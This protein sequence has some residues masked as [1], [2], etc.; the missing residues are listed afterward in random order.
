MVLSEGDLGFDGEAYREQLV[1][2][3]GPVRRELEEVRGLLAR[4]LRAPKAELSEVF[5][6]LRVTSGRLLRP[7]VLLL[8]GRAAGDLTPGHLAA[9]V[10]VEL[11]H[12]ASLIH[13]DI[14]DGTRLRRGPSACRPAGDPARLCWWGTWSSDGRW[15]RREELRGRLLA[16]GAC[17]RVR[18][19]AEDWLRQAEQSLQRLG[20]SPAR[21]ALRALA[22]YIRETF[23]VPTGFNRG[24]ETA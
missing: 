12:T 4:W 24:F 9:A 10:A 14:V 7:A 3:W 2:I 11:L 18:E 15:S 23:D 20:E 16:S 21:E 13:D 5:R 19:T 17:N 8:A 1:R 22:F 6:G